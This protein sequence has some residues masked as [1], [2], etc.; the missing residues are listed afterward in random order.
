MSGLEPQISSIKSDCST[1]CAST[2]A[3]FG[4][5]FGKFVQTWNITTTTTTT[6]TNLKSIK[7]TR[8]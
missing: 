5:L 7:N 2:T 3:R 1:N 8:K 6:A 4:Q